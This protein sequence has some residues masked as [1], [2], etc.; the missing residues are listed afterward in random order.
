MRKFSVSQDFR[1]SLEMSGFR[2]RGVKRIGV[3]II[4]LLIALSPSTVRSESEKACDTVKNAALEAALSK[5]WGNEVQ[6]PLAVSAAVKEYLDNPDDKKFNAATNA[7]ANG[8]LGLFVPGAGWSM[9]AGK[10]TID[11]VEY[12]IDTARAL[13]LDGYLCNGGGFLETSFFQFG[14]VQ[15]IWSGINCDNY[16][17]KITTLKDFAKLEEKFKKYK[18]YVLSR[19][20]I[21]K[22]GDPNYESYSTILDEEW[23]ILER[24]WKAKVGAALIEK[25][26]TD[27]IREAEAFKAK[28]ACKVDPAVGASEPKTGGGKHFQLVNMED[29]IAQTVPEWKKSISPGSITIQ[30]P[31]GHA[32][33]TW[34]GPP[35]RVEAEGF[36]MTLN[37]SVTAD[38][39]NFAT[40]IKV[41]SGFV[42]AAGNN[43]IGVLA[44]KKGAT[45]K[46]SLEVQ[47]KPAT[48]DFLKPGDPVYLSVGGCNAGNVTYIY[49][50]QE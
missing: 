20:T 28:Q 15:T 41:V 17:D 29:E 40:G 50:F 42:G 30:T 8:A 38:V 36:Q 33:C 32:E 43:E 7:L 11:S 9:V 37:V 14:D 3:A 22:P 4:A 25:L 6:V 24:N 2:H 39:S 12:T 34:S 19:G 31:F 21:G 1:T 10:L 44:E 18:D 47:L 13:Q 46:K 5:L 26:R 45:D 23:K 49:E 27:L 48:F 35:Q 16:A